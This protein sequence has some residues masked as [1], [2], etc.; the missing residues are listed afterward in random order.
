[1]NVTHC[2]KLGMNTQG[3]HSTYQLMSV[4]DLSWNRPEFREM[5]DHDCEQFVLRIW[6][7]TTN[8]WGYDTTRIWGDGRLIWKSANTG[9]LNWLDSEKRVWITVWSWDEHMNLPLNL[10]AND[11]EWF[12]IRIR[13]RFWI[14][15]MLSFEIS[16]TVWNEWVTVC[17]HCATCTCHKQLMVWYDEN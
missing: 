10:P 15:K 16:W 7:W 12:I 13:L 3:Y 1:M 14:W 17:T 11:C 6:L 5:K 8:C 2:L 4:S 9:L